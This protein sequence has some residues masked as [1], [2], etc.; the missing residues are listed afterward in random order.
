MRTFLQVVTRTYKRPTMLAA[1]MASIAAL[2]S[3]VRHTLLRDEKGIGVAA[4]N[5][6]LAEFEPV[7]RYVWVLDDDDVCTYDNLLA[8]LKYLAWLQNAPPAFIVRMDHG[9]ELGILPNAVGW[10]K[11]PR[12]AGIGCS[13]IITRRDVWM[14]HRQAWATGRYA[15]DFDFISA[16]WESWQRTI[17]WHD[18]VASR[19]Q[20][21]S[22][23]LPEAA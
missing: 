21:I 13:A 1:N 14:R 15:A 11:A 17:V 10:R 18:V 12:E 9:P 23:G 2:G 4:A 3:D 6:Q 19:C 5:A 8:D 16:V 7:A 22:R 20:R